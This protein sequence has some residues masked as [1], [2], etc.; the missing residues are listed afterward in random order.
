MAGEGDDTIIGNEAANV[1]HS[2]GGDDRIHAGEGADSVSAGTGSNLIDLAEATAA[3][4]TAIFDTE[5]LQL[6]YSTIYGFHQHGPFSDILEFTN[7]ALTRANDQIENISSSLAA[8][9]T[10]LATNKVGLTLQSNSDFILFSSE[11]NDLGSPQEL[12]HAKDSGG[13]FEINHFATLYGANLDLDFWDFNL[14][15]A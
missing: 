5:S 10:K 1:I 6:G 13:S 9:G 4:D 14:H 15:I 3:R 2:Y 7:F 8:I 11:T 12:F